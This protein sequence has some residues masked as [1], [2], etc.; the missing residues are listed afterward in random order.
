MTQ[1]PITLWCSLYCEGNEA[2]GEMDIDWGGGHVVS[3]PMCQECADHLQKNP[4]LALDLVPVD[5]LDL[6]IQ[7]ALGNP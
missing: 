5:V 7:E 4:A 2:V 1:F 3:L 6:N